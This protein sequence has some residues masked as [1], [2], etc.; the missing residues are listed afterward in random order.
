MSSPPGRR[1]NQEHSAKDCGPLQ[2]HL[3]GDHSPERVTQDVAA[4][5]LQRIEK[6]KRMLGHTGDARWN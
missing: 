6:G 4:G 3:L 5:K 2:H 1:P